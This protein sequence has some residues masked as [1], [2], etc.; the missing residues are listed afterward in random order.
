[1]FVDLMKRIL[2][3]FHR[4]QEGVQWEARCDQDCGYSERLDCLSL[5]DG[6]EH[7]D[8][9]PLHVRSVMILEDEVVYDL[10]EGLNCNH[11]GSASLG[12]SNLDDIRLYMVDTRKPHFL[13]R[14]TSNLLKNETKPSFFHASS[15]YASGKM[16]LVELMAV[17]FDYY[18]DFSC[19]IMPMSHI[20]KTTV[21]ILQM[22]LSCMRLH[23][24]DPGEGKEAWNAWTEGS[25]PQMIR[26]V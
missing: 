18:I 8:L 5:S 12:I 19:K 6:R 7:P 1:M 22:F 14:S 24:K 3:F 11:C 17:F 20:R 16:F 25:R 13:I 26:D 4:V 9:L 10:L 21:C 23:S 2:T 15:F